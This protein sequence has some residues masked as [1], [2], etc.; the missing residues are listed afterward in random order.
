MVRV[1]GEERSRRGKHTCACN[2]VH[3]RGGRCLLLLL[4][5][6]QQDVCMTDLPLR[7]DLKG[8]ER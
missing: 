4:A 5:A 1:P 3:C 7:E 2:P 8:G 6:E